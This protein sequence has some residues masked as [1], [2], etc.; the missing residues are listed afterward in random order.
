[1]KIK[2]IVFSALLMVGVGGTA[3]AADTATG[4][5]L[6]EKL[7][8]NCHI[9]APGKDQQQ[10]TA[11]IPSFMAVAKKDG[12]TAEKIAG[13]I[14]IPHPPMPEIQLTNHEIA[15]LAAYIMLLKDK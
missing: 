11:G 10:V 8:S 7:C 3:Q 9:V 5:Q 2:S 6:A 12:Q 13:F 4:K 14:I 15:N 1:M